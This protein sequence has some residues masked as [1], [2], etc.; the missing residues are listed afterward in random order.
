MT[1]LGSLVYRRSGRTRR[2]SSYDV[3]GGN[4]DNWQI[5]VG[6]TITLADVK[7][8]GC[9]THLWFTINCPD[10]RY[11]LR[12][13]VLRAYWDGEEQP[14]VEVPVGDF[15]NLG[16]GL[17]ASRASIPFATSANPDQ[18]KKLGGNMA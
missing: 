1:T 3:S 11:H 18:E 17:A 16:H 9:I 4:G 5:P 2:C 8:A 7:G 10:D 15:F 12:H 14:S 6:E 13:L